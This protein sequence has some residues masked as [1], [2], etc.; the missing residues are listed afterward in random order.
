MRVVVDADR[1]RGHGVCSAISPEVF[2]LTD[3]GYTVAAE[4]VPPE[5]EADVR[6]AL[7]SCPEHA[8]T[9]S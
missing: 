9:L 1:C 7:A 8:I 6:T 4:R 3:D 5:R 2:T